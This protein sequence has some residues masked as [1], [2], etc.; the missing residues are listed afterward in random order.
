MGP[1]ITPK[2]FHKQK[3]LEKLRSS[4][5]KIMNNKKVLV[6]G[7]LESTNDLR[8][9]FVGHID[10]KKLMKIWKFIEIY[11]L[12]LGQAQK[13]ETRFLL[14]TFIDKNHFKKGKYGKT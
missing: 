6:Y 7:L 9:I 14:I 4:F 11:S 1:T 12:L 10:F 2:R 3:I 13:Q 8:T 5:S